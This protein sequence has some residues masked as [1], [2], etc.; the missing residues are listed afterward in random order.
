MPMKVPMPVAH[1]DRPSEFRLD[2]L[3]TGFGFVVPQFE[4]T[5]RAI[6]MHNY[7]FPGQSMFDTAW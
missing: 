4:R 7:P 6:S 1:Q 3:D 2:L 5:V